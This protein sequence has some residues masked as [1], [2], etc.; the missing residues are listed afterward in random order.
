M[1]LEGLAGLEGLEGP[2]VRKDEVDQ[3]ALEGLAG[4][5]APKDPGTADA[6]VADTLTDA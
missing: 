3:M 1:A 4:L 6:T 5:E 2:A